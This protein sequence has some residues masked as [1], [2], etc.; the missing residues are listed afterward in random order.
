MALVS[1]DY[2]HAAS[3]LSQSPDDAGLRFE[4]SKRLDC[5]DRNGDNRR[6][7]Y[8]ADFAPGYEIAFTPWVEMECAPGSKPTTRSN[9]PIRVD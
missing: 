5:P 1:E 2:Q 6:I 7:A 9:V 3:I 4:L 8:F